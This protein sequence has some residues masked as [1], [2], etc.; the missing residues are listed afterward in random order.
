[1]LG[2]GLFVCL[3]CFFL[4]NRIVEA[5][6]ETEPGGQGVNGCLEAAFT[7]KRELRD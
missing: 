2:F 4:L 1:M 3:F 6:N 5:S 7:V